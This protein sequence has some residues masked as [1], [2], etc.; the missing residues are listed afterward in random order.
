MP[1]TKGAS[2]S[3]AMDKRALV[4]YSLEGFRSLRTNISIYLRTPPNM[5]TLY[6]FPKNQPTTHENEWLKGQSGE[7]AKSKNNWE[8]LH[9]RLN[10]KRKVPSNRMDEKSKMMV[11]VE[12]RVRRGPTMAGR[13]GTSPG[14]TTISNGSHGNQKARP[15]TKTVMKVWEATG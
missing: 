9:N 1:E 10:S 8:I 14:F 7:R 2:L 13:C 12:L 4:N 3:C 15:A 6:R 5:A 11:G